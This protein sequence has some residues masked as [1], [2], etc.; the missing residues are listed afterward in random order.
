MIGVLGHD[1]ALVRL[2][3]VGDNPSPP[4]MYGLF[5]TK[6]HLYVKIFNYN[7]IGPVK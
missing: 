6:M 1:Y 2:Y 5:E 7:K 3:W 4:K